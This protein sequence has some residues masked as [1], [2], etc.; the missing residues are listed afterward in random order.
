MFSNFAIKMTAII[1]FETDSDAIADDFKENLYE[2][3]LKL[4]II[5]IIDV[6]T[7]SDF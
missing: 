7:S 6:L 4:I 3:Y 5:K 1:K 2:C